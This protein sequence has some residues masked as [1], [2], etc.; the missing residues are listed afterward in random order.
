MTSYFAL[1]AVETQR[2]FDQAFIEDEG[3]PGASRLRISN[4]TV[5]SAVQVSQAKTTTLQLAVRPVNVGFEITHQLRRQSASRIVM[6]V[7]QV[8]VMPPQKQA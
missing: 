2:R 4:L 6:Q 1:T 7:E 5:E 3:P 8:A